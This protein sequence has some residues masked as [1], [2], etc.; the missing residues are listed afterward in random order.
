MTLRR[1]ENTAAVSGAVTLLWTA[2]LLGV[3]VTL[4]GV[5]TAYARTTPAQ[6]CAAAKLNATSK[7]AA[8][9]LKCYAKAAT[10]ASSVDPSCLTAAETK[11]SNAFAKAEAKGS[12]VT[13]GDAAA[14]E[15]DVDNFVVGVVAQL[16]WSA[17]APT[18]TATPTQMS[19][20]TPTQTSTPTP[21]ETPAGPTCTDGLRNGNETDVDCGGGTCGGCAAGKD[22]QAGSDC[23]SGVCSAGRCV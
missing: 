20:P 6:K 17:P 13:S 11:F 19:T 21:T 18:P 22:C 5:P 16:P 3:T 10:K 1:C 7:N 8:A 2:V 23:L 15:T 12:C 4:A 9:K 14:I